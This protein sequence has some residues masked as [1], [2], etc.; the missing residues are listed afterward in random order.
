MFEVVSII[1]TL[2]SI[3][4]GIVSWIHTTIKR[5]KVA[6]ISDEA[7]R[8]KEEQ[9][10]ATCR[11]SIL[12]RVP[13]YCKNSEQ[14]F[15]TKTGIAKYSM[16]ISWIQIDCLRENIPFDEEYYKDR[17]ES[18]LDAPQKKTTN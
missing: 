17:I 12:E 8:A 16:V 9:R 11:L 10:I 3:A 18:I 7:E 6:S 4:L 1:I 13:E 2:F 14:V 5:R 15:G